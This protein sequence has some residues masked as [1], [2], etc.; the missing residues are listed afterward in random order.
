M[1]WR[2]NDA[3][4]GAVTKTFHWLISISVIAL[5]VVGFYMHDLPNTPD[6]IKIY[7][8]H[9]SFGITVLALMTLRLVWRVA[10]D[11]KRPPMPAGMPR[12]QRIGADISHVMLYVLVFAQTLSGWAFNSA[13]NF[14]LRWF[15]QFSVPKLVQPDKEL[16]ALAG[17]VHEFVAWALIVFIVLHVLAALKHHFVD[18]D[19]TLARMLPGRSRRVDIAAPHVV[20][21]AP[22]EPPVVVAP[23]SPVPAPGDKS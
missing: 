20:A 9:K 11:G 4:W 3:A 19:A 15:G 8:L 2:T 6:K 12:W 1:Q 7:A 22:V 13:A 16:R 14:P 21:P 5:L 17:D 18:R 10:F 23:T